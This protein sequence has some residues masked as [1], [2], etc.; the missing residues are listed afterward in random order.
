M[1]KFI[2]FYVPGINWWQTRPEK[3]ASSTG[4]FTIFFVTFASWVTSL[5]STH[6]Q[7]GF[8]VHVR[9]TDDCLTLRMTHLG[10]LNVTFISKCRNDHILSSLDSWGKKKKKVLSF[11]RHIH[12]STWRTISNTLFLLLNLQEI[13]TYQEIVA[14]RI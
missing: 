11:P 14:K 1:T 7:G 9:I 10:L 5:A 6:P 8:L 2:F 3:E 4:L 13:V 12:S